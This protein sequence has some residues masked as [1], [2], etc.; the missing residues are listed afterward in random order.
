MTIYSIAIDG[1]SGAGKSTLAKALAEKL[2]I[3]YL[4]T[5]A[6]YRAFAYFVIKEGFDIYDEKALMELLPKFSIDFS[7]GHIL[8]NGENI[9][10]YI[11]TQEIAMAAS[12]VSTFQMVRK[13]MVDV[14]QRLA[15]NKTIILDGRDIGTVVLP[16]AKDK[17]Y[18]TARPEIRAK[19]RLLQMNSPNIGYDEIYN[20]ILKRDNQDMTRKNSPLKK[21]KDAILIDTSDETPEDTLYRILEIIQRG[22]KS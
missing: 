11:R 6:M 10:E 17:F 20:Q 7:Q 9:E 18:I 14:Q 16:H 13:K 1:P 3:D 15:E 5:G 4:D 8:L 12:I 2:N 19:R 21:A 22:F